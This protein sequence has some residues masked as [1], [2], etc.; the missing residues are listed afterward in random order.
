[1]TDVEVVRIGTEA[2]EC[3]TPLEEAFI[4]AYFSPDSPARFSI[5]R[6]ARTIDIMPK[7][8]YAVLDSPGVQG[9]LRAYLHDLGL[10]QAQNVAALGK[11]RDDPDAAHKDVIAAAKALMQYDYAMGQRSA[12]QPD[13]SAPRTE[14]N[15]QIVGL[16]KEA[17]NKPEPFEP[18]PGITLDPVEIRSRGLNRLPALDE[19]GNGQS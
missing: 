3:L 4:A 1:M 8:A 14:I 18:V 13:S 11:I 15:V 12:G 6:T 19:G 7:R 16:L 17:F 10:S 2:V 5:I 9:Y